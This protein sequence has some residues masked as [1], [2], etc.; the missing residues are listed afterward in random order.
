[1]HSLNN[2]EEGWDHRRMESSAVAVLL[3]LQKRPQISTLFSEVWV[4]FKG[5]EEA[6]WKL[7]NA[8]KVC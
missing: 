4:R 8:D 3:N 5:G 6:V 2:K 1:M 7:N